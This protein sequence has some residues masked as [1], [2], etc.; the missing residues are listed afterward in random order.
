MA[1]LNK[2]PARPR[3]LKANPAYPAK[4]AVG[5]IAA[6]LAVACSTPSDKEAPVSDTNHSS[7]V[8]GAGGVGG[9]TGGSGGSEQSSTQCRTNADVVCFDP[10]DGTQYAGICYSNGKEYCDRVNKEC[11]E[12]NI[13]G[14]GGV[15]GSG[16]S[17]GVGGNYGGTGGWDLGGAAP[18]PWCEPADEPQCVDPCTGE[19]YEAYC[20]DVG[21]WEC[22][23]G[24]TCNYAG[25]DAESFGP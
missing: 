19:P 10:C 8:A 20:N 14:P 11:D 24:D 22:T 13:G 23:L 18:E 9:S 17:G 3:S 15:G 4:L 5:V 21:Q 6:A 1:Q 25:G 16:G 7:S 2:T 12:F